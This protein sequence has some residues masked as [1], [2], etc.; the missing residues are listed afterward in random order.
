MPP[1]ASRSARVAGLNQ[2]IGGAIEGEVDLGAAIGAAA[3]GIV[4]A[5]LGEVRTA[6]LRLALG[7]GDDLVFCHAGADEEALHRGGAAAG[8]LLIVGLRAKRVGVTGKR[9]LLVRV[10]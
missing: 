3:V 5:A 6:R 10:R 9:E 8:E 4:L 2:R 1:A 7:Q